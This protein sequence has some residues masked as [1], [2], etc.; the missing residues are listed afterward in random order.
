M[1]VLVT[2]AG[3]FIGSHLVELLV[4][5][6]YDVRAF[7]HY[8]SASHNFNLE[9]V[10]DDVSE[11]I[12]VVSG[13]IADG[14]AVD[15][16]VEN[17]DFVFHLAALIGI[18]YSYVAPAAYV[19]TNISGTLNVLEACRRHSVGRMV[20]V[21]SSEVY[22]KAQ[23]VPIDEKHPLVGQSPYSATKIGAD[24]LADSYWRSFEI[25]VV[26]V[27][28]FNT[29]GPRQSARAIIPTVVSQA[30]TQDV[31]RLGNLEP[32]R[33]LNF[34]LD[35][36]AGMV[37][38]AEADASNVLGEVIN[39]GCGE[40]KSIRQIVESVGK[41]LGQEL[42]VETEKARTRPDKSEVMHLESNPAKAQALM[43][44]KSQYTFVDGLEKTVDYIRDNLGKYKPGYTV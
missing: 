23:Y 31:V 13:D 20:H 34:V 29:F 16:A 42:V 41:V 5:K 15:R 43:G 12:E 7:T 1:K 37:A 36:V 8:N 40:G 21:S 38:A 10:S 14:F 4:T 28:P 22:G 32:V 35:T 17:C 24:Q 39:L 6:G 26:T 18:P 30:L 19:S 25:P 11:A 33:E 27:R 2:G 44:W 3:G 9:E